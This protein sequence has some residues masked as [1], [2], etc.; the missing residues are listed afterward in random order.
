M[1]QRFV[2]GLLLGRFPKGGGPNEIADRRMR[3]GS[4]LARGCRSEAR[5]IILSTLDARGRLDELPFMAEMFR[6][7]GRTFQV[8]KRAHKTCDPA[9]GIIGRS[10]TNTVHLENLRCDGAAHDGCEADCLIFWKEAWL[11]RV[12]AKT[13][14]SELAPAQG[15]GLSMDAR[16][17]EETIRSGGKIAPA[18]GESEP[19]RCQNTQVK[20]ASQARSNGGTRASTSRTTHPVTSGCGNW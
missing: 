6:Y 12:D 18:P 8:S 9:V 16:S 4:L 15:N 19:P 11:K 1:T 5:K 17:A 13:A 3:L 2:E 7:C 10:M 20:F 14:A